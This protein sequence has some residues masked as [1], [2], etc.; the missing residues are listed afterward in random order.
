MFSRTHTSL[1]GVVNQTSNN[2][3]DSS[4]CGFVETPTEKVTQLKMADWI[5]TV[6]DDV[7]LGDLKIPG[8]HNSAADASVHMGRFNFMAQCQTLAIVSQLDLGIRHFDIRL[9]LDDSIL[10]VYHGPCKFDS[11]LIEIMSTFDSFLAVHDNEFIILEIHREDS[12][13]AKR[14]WISDESF[15]ASLNE[16]FLLFSSRIY[17]LPDPNP[18]LAQI[19]GKII[20]VSFKHLQNADQLLRFRILP[21]LECSGS[22]RCKATADGLKAKMESLS[23]GMEQSLLYDGLFVNQANAVGSVEFVPLLPSPK[24]M[25]QFINEAVE[26]RIEAGTLSFRGALLFDFPELTAS[27]SLVR[28]VVEMNRPCTVR[29]DR[30]GD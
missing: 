3:A 29:S 24:R 10:T 26:K 9:K 21:T 16:A 12:G 22:Y 25:A 23:V 5:S 30:E 1:Q 4:V 11:T 2:E 20:L 18:S 8:T 7:L 19:R 13:F 14:R 27:G 15:A 28:K 6:R 17:D